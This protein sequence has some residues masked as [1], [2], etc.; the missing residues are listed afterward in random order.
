MFTKNRK[1][2]KKIIGYV[3]LTCISLLLQTQG[4]ERDNGAYVCLLYKAA[5]Q[6]EEEGQH[7]IAQ[8]QY[9]EL[10]YKEAFDIRDEHA[11]IEYEG[12]DQTSTKGRTR[13]KEDAIKG[14]EEFINKYN[15]GEV[16]NEELLQSKPLIDEFIG[17]KEADM[18]ILLSQIDSLPR[19]DLPKFGKK[20]KP[21]PSCKLT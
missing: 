11:T 12:L 20:M 6:N 7:N 14:F 3:C 5:I 2:L 4:M 18:A 21:L 1:E 19:V 15:K 16:T 17:I 8:H 9:E 13:M 10:E